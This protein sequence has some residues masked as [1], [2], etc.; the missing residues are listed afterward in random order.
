MLATFFEPKRSQDAPKTRQEAPRRS[1]TPQ[2]TPKAP[3]T[4]HFGSILED[5]LEEFAVQPASVNIR[6]QLQ[7]SQ[8]I[9]AALVALS[10]SSFAPQVLGW[11]MEA[12][13]HQ[14]RVRNRC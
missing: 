8:N 6:T 1:K 9:H 7:K 3:K 14:N 12:S 4:F 11:K 10:G 2:D 5:F 13:W